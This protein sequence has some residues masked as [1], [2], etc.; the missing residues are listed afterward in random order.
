VSLLDRLLPIDPRARARFRSDRAAMTGLGL[1][2]LVSALAIAGPWLARFDPNESDFNLARD[3]FGAPPGPSFTHWLGCDA[4]FRDVFARLASGARVS[5]GVALVATLISIS[6][7]AFVGIASGLSA[8]TRARAIDVIAMRACDVLLALPFLL[9]VTAVG[10]AVGR[11]DIGTMLAIL[12]LTSWAGTARLVRAKTLVL[13]EQ[14]YVLAARAL[15]A[16]IPRIV[17]RHIVPNLAGILTITATTTIGQMILAEAV[18]GYL[19]VGVQPPRA[20]WG[21]MLHEAEPYLAVRFTLA[22]IPGFSILLAVLGFGRVGEGLRDAL[23]EREPARSRWPVDLA[24]ATAALLLLSGVTPNAVRPP[25]GRE[26]ADSPPS[27]GGTLRV[28]TF[29][30]VRTLDPAIAYDEGSLPII[31]LAFARLLTW[32]ATGE[33]ALDLAASMDASPDGLR[34]AFRL[35]DDA[36]FQDGSVVHA[37][38]I[39]RSLERSLHPKTPSPG[40][41]FYARL[42]GFDAF[43]AGKVAHLEGLRVDGERT[44]IFEL[45]EP[46][47][48]FPSLLTLGFAAPVCA[49][50]GA[51]ADARAKELPCGAGPFRITS[52]DPEAGIHLARHDGYYA[53]GKPYLDAISWTTSMRPATQRYAFERGELDYLRELSS[54]DTA[55]FRAD[56]AWSRRGR[57]VTKRSTTAIFLNTEVAPFDRRAVR[58]AV[59]LAIDPKVLELVRP[60][61]EATDRVIPPSIPGPARTP[62]RAPDLD[63][64]R[65]LMREAGLAFDPAT[66]QGGWPLPI[67]Y[68]VPPETFEQQAAEIYQQQLAKIG[69]RVRLRLLPFASYLAEIGRRRTAPMGWTGWNADYPDASNFFEPFASEAIR[70][71][72]SQNY[73]FLASK[74]LDDVVAR[75]RTTLAPQARIALYAKAETIVRD[76]AAWLPV[77]HARALELWHPYVRGYA[78]HAVLSQRF[79]DVWIDAAAR[80][81]T[82]SIRSRRAPFGLSWSAR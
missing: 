8:N 76:E 20:T 81:A 53:P 17:T 77:Y 66:G 50:M 37:S 14:D 58:R 5:L 42:R 69:L 71:E 78:P 2:G 23:G 75:A 36:R 18:L 10:A 7:G 56:P 55:L 28:A 39:K 26:G 61:V 52:F 13:R 63:A 40:A 70:D 21:R 9:F 59:G 38:D 31:D 33:I 25:I 60:D 12:G 79:D 72:G 29:V 82:L 73:S 24:I 64:A 35:R 51:F 48:A 74:E 32:S 4:L 65:A 68:V 41:S 22:A 3:R 45:T 80:T 19:T 47:A 1:V 54:P 43:H 16:S 15:G 67:D 6:L 62:L 11:A 30:G 27:R 57:W 46:D 49:S 34:Y 44:I